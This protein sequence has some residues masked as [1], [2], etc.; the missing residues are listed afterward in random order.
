MAESLEKRLQEP[1]AAWFKERMRVRRLLLARIGAGIRNYDR[2]LAEMDA[3]DESRAER[4][5]VSARL[6]DIEARLTALEQQRS[7]RPR[8][9]R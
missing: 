7:R 2:M 3:A 5:A 8:R 6:D 4:A 1:H 9:R